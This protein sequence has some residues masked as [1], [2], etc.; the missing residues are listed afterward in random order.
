MRR[1]RRTVFEF[2]TPAWQKAISVGEA[3]SNEQF[4]ALTNEMRDLGEGERPSAAEF[5]YGNGLNILSSR[6]TEPSSQCPGTA[7]AALSNEQAAA[8]FNER[9]TL[10]S[11]DGTGKRSSAMDGTKHASTVPPHTRPAVQPSSGAGFAA[12]ALLNEQLD[13]LSN[14][15]SLAGC[16]SHPSAAVGDA[17]TRYGVMLP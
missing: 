3:L 14:E 13:A 1:Q 6:R 9:S 4:D 12:D 16:A 7:D 8:L 2:S 10:S 5:A 15:R 11:L 17:R